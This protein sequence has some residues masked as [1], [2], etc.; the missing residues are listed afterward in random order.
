MREI[1][2]RPGSGISETAPRWPRPGPSHV[3]ANGLFSQAPGVPP[4]A[5]RS[6]A[7][8][9]MA[10]SGPRRTCR[11]IVD[12]VAFRRRGSVESGA[13][14]SWPSRS[15]W[16]RNMGIFALR[17]VAE[18]GHPKKNYR[19]AWKAGS[20]KLPDLG[21]QPSAAGNPWRRADFQAVPGVYQLHRAAWGALRIVDS[22][23]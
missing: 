15:P 2:I 14:G 16:E 18:N 8:T 4:S 5:C 23:L 19:W 21:A 22:S 20:T 10:C 11:G 9:P 7:A 1:P 17:F 13:C 6:R 12:M 3:L